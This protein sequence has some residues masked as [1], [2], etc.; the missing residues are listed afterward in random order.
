MGILMVRFVR[1]RF[2]T[3]AM[4]AAAI[5]ASTTASAWAFS[6]QMLGP[7]DN[8]NYNFNYTD[9]SHPHLDSQSTPSDPNGPGFH[10]SVEHGQSGPF[11]GFRSDNHFFDNNDKPMAPDYSRPL[12]NGD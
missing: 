2:A 5:I 4:T 1:L 8:G 7:T 10:F 9:P 6:Q 11:S 3:I 12:G